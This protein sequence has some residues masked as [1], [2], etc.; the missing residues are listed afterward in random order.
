MILGLQTMTTVADLPVEAELLANPAG[1]G[2]WSGSYDANSGEQT[3]SWILPFTLITDFARLALYTAETVTI[4]ATPPVTTVTR[5]V[6]MVCEFDSAL[7]CLRVDFRALSAEEAEDAT[8]TPWKLVVATCRF[9]PL[10]YPV[11]GDSAFISLR[12]RANPKR[13][14]I[15]N[16][17]YTLVDDANVFVEAVAQDVGIPI[18]EE[19]IEVTWHGITDLPGALATL[20]PMMDRVNSDVITLPDLGMACQPGTLH[21]AGR[22]ASKTISFGGVVKSELSATLLYRSLPW[23]RAVGS[24][25]A[26]RWVQPRPITATS[27]KTLTGY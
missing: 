26:L 14:T 10:P 23:N 20:S 15:P 19:Q 27:F 17:A 13:I 12:L 4:S 22:D 21:L 2:A 5:I 6:P 16:F 24:G 25:G 11:S 9:G 3:M 1:N 8:A 18:A 7:N